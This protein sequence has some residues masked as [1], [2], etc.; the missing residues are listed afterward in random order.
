MTNPTLAQALDYAARGW[1]V[2]PC[3]PG[4]KIPATKHG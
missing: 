1:K 3:L 4:Q 2:F